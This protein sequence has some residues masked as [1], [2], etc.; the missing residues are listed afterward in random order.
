MRL[1]RDINVVIG[2]LRSR[3]GASNAVLVELL[4]GNGVWLCSVPLFLEYE[5]VMMRAEFRLETGHDEAALK[6]FLGGIASAIEPVDLHFLWRPQLGDAK[7]E[8]VLE[9]AINGGADALVTHN[10]RDFREVA[11]RFGIDAISPRTVLGGMVR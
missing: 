5:A 4:R 9:A 3:H 1:V 10:L 6:G 2:A 11:P 7:D 8:M